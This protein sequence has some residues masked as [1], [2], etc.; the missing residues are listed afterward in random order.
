MARAIRDELIDELLQDDSSPQGG[1]AR[2]CAASGR[3]AAPR[4]G[5]SPGEIG[6]SLTSPWARSNLAQPT[7]F[8][9]NGEGVTL[10]VQGRA[11]RFDRVMEQAYEAADVFRPDDIPPLASFSGA[12]K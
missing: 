6:Q 11:E 9:D 1:R 2:I 3:S 10:A 7:V 4:S 8:V 12:R 5:S